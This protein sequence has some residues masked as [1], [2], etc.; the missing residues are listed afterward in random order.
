MAR[1]KAR[2]TAGMP[3]ERFEWK[4]SLVR[5]L[6]RK[7]F[8]RQDVVELFRFLDWVLFL[9]AEMKRPFAEELRK[10]EEEHRMP[11]ITSVEEVGI[12][13]GRLGKGREAVLDALEVRFEKENPREFEPQLAEIWDE[14]ALKLLHRAA[15]RAASLDEFR[16][17]IQTARRPT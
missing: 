15:I 9:P 13:T 10:I 6:Y 16:L 1:L 4:L 14:E 3:H 7:G 2:A 17:A 5:T 8:A 12:E 11:F